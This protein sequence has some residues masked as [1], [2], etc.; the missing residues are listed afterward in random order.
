[1]VADLGGGAVAT[2]SVEDS[3]KEDNEAIVVLVQCRSSDAEARE[4][5]KR[6]VAAA[7][8]QAMAVEST[9]VLVP[10]HGLPQTSSGKLSRA[11]AKANFLGGVYASADAGASA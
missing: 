9:V 3:N 10:P 7:L 8:Q 2:I 1:M 11:K 4:K 6:D 5:L